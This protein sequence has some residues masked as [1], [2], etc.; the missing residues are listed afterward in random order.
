MRTILSAIVRRSRDDRYEGISWIGPYCLP[1][2]PESGSA[3]GRREEKICA[4]AGELVLHMLFWRLF[5]GTGQFGPIYS[6]FG[7]D[8]PVTH[9]L[10][11]NTIYY[12]DIIPLEFY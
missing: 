10:N 1:L 3:S 9:I 4:L 8:L 6:R 5:T 2:K 7:P 12:D 11:E